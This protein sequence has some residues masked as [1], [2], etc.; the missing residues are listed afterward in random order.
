[1]QQS[2]K[3]RDIEKSL[4]KKGFKEE[5]GDHK[6]YYFYLNGKKT[7]IKTK[8]SHNNQEYSKGLV[9]ALMIQLHLT[10]TQLDDLIKCPLTE[11]DLI[12]IYSKELK[13][14]ESKLEYLTKKTE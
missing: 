7:T 3:S 12:E 5:C 13:R 9:K 14:I 11:N 4:K 10:R 8:T 1:M 2:Y 6:F